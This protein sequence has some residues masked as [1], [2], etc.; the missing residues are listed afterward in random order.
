MITPFRAMAYGRVQK[1]RVGILLI[2]E[3]WQ[4]L[5]CSRPQKEGKLVCPKRKHEND[6]KAAEDRIP[7]ERKCYPHE[8]SPSPAPRFTAAS[9]RLPLIF[10]I[11]AAV[12]KYDKRDFF[13]YV[14]KDHAH[15][16]GV[17]DQQRE[18]LLVFDQAKQIGAS[19]QYSIL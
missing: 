4:R 10:A 1:I 11:K 18:L 19:G 12:K 13:P 15:S 3:N 2:S 17:V 5:W 8:G 14:S 16:L 7:A 6:Q 9:P